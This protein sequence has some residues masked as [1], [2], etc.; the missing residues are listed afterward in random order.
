[1]Q[2]NEKSIHFE[3]RLRE[4]ADSLEYCGSRPTTREIL[5]VFLEGLHPRIQQRVADQAPLD[6]EDALILAQRMENHPV[7]NSN[8]RS[9]NQNQ[10][11]NQEPNSNQTQS[12]GRQDER[13][14]CSHCKRMGHTAEKCFK[15]HP[16]LRPSNSRSVAA[17]TLPALPVP[18]LGPK[19]L[20]K[21]KVNGASVV[22]LVDSGADVTLINPNTIARLQLTVQPMEAEVP[23]LAYDK[24]GASLKHGVK[25]TLDVDGNPSKPFVAMVPAVLEQDLLLGNDFLRQEKAILDYDKE[26]LEILGLVLPLHPDKQTHTSVC[27]LTLEDADEALVQKTETK[28][29]KLADVDLSDCSEEKKSI[30]TINSTVAKP[31]DFG[32]NKKCLPP[33]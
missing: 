10:K 30:A 26:V 5:H 3:F 14:K 31:A 27:Q 18:K 8:R 25:L 16:E 21:A 19:C 9:D 24:A 23:L 4:L 17:V 33:H 11:R 29:P 15:I 2:N 13:P 22:S 12:T 28:A 1:M 6:L 20:L 32:I 7:K